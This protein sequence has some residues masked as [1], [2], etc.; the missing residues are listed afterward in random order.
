[1]KPLVQFLETRV[2]HSGPLV[3]IA[4]ALVFLGAAAPAAATEGGVSTRATLLVGFP[5]G[6]DST[7]GVLVV[8]GTVIPD[9]G[10]TV[11]EGLSLSPD[12]MAL[13][14]EDATL[15]SEERRSRAFARLSRELTS[16]FRLERVEASFS[17]SHRLELEEPVELSPPA[18]D[19]P[20]RITIELLGFDTRTATYRVRFVDR[21]V[22]LADTRVAAVRGRQA[23]IGGL[24]GESA[25]YLFL[26]LGPAAPPSSEQTSS[27]PYRVM[28]GITAPRRVSTVMPRYTE[29]A[30]KERIQGMVIV[31]TVIEKD[32]TVSDLKVLKG[33]PHGLSEAAVEAIRQWTFEPARDEQGRPVTVYYNLTVNFTLDSPPDSG[34]KPSGTPE[35]DDDPGSPDAA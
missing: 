29:E 17:E 13:T 25:P 31:Q 22:V 12:G 10:Q 1:M 35:P 32:G 19:S 26:V 30:K 34:E 6:D 14:L 15:S 9:L 18:P 8:P 27:P 20:L 7:E 4:L 16:T 33:L 21:N 2:P 11:P 24:D 3:P 5:S 28:D 23:V